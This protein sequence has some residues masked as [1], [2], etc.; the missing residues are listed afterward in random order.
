M[1][2]LGDALK[3]NLDQI[4]QYLY[5]GYAR[6]DRL[7]KRTERQ[8]Q[9]RPGDFADEQVWTF[10]LGCGYA[11]AGQEGVARLTRLLTGSNQR[12]PAAPRIWF[13]VLPIQ[14]RKGEGRTRLDL[15]LG[16]LGRRKR[17][18]SGIEVGNDDPSWICFCEMKWY[19]DISTRVSHDAHR[20]QLA[21][22]IE[23]AL[24]FQGGGRYADNVHV[25]LVTPKIF[26]DA[27]PK[28]RLY[29]YKFEE[30]AKD[31]THIV[32]DLQACALERRN[33]QRWSYPADLAERAEPL[34]LHWVTYDELFEDLPESPLAAD[35]TSFWTQ[36]GN[37]QGRVPAT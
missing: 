2:A 17:T 16:T 22:V 8:E 9:E 29:Q 32:E 3:K 27:E 1:N 14:P 25:T 28:S 36:Y 21:R 15:A 33:Q 12:A 19:S 35:L 34:T 11:I 13:E 20:N 30:Y 26:R 10:L 23:N 6:C 5:V 37:Y 4:N 24:S 31:P 7:I 18:K